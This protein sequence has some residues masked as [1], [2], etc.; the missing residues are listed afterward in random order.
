MITD[1][2]H[3]QDTP[4]VDVLFDAVMLTSF[5]CTGLVLGYMSLY[6]FHVE[7][8]RRVPARSAARLIAFII[9]LCSFAIYLGRD[10]RWNTWDLFVNPAGILFDVSDRL[11]NPRAHPQMFVTILSFFLLLSVL[12]LLVWNV[13]HTLRPLPRR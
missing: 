3:L 4:R 2:I 9:F 5:V 10:L 12:Y 11:I 7:L 6:M 1:Y 13:I 8:R